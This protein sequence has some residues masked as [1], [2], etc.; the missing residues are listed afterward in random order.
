MVRK[1]KIVKEIL[2]F[3]CFNGSPDFNLT[4]FV[5]IITNNLTISFFEA[6]YKN[7]VDRKY[8]SLKIPKNFP[9]SPPFLKYI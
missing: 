1:K 7:P 6:I 8:P 3:P 2:N 9:K 5:T 4:Y